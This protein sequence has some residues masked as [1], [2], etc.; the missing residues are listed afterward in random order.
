M[1]KRHFRD[2]IA[3]VEAAGFE[4]RDFTIGRKHIKLRVAKPGRER[5]R[6]IVMA[7]TPRCKPHAQKAVLRDCR[8]EFGGAV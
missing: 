2:C 4:V 8:R 3:A 6:T 7:G 1:M 5:A